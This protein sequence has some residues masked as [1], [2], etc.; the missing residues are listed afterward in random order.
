ME[1]EP[2]QKK[3]TRKRDAAKTKLLLTRSTLHEKV[4]LPEVISPRIREQVWGVPRELERIGAPAGLDA[5]GG[6]R[7]YQKQPPPVGSERR[8]QKM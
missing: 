2:K 5:A 6:E 1:S 4:N 7:E 3:K 8:L